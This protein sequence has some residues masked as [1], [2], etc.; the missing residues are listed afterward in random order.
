MVTDTEDVER[1]VAGSPKI[2]HE[3]AEA[4]A[5]QLTGEGCD[6]WVLDGALEVSRRFEFQVA[7]VC[8]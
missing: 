6:T 4:P 3:K 8:R 2:V 5:D 1:D 7:R